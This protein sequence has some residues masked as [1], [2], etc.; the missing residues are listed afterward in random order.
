MEIDMQHISKAFGPNV[1]LK[2]VN[3]SVKGG[4]VH[5]LMG[6]NG[7]GKST[8]MNI[9][10]GLL[11]PNGG[12]IKVDGK[13]THFASALEAEQHGISFIHQEMNNFGEMPI[14]DNMFLNKEIKTRFGFIDNV[15]MK[16]IAQESLAKLDVKLDLNQPIGNL[17]VGQQQM[18]EIAKSLMTDAKIIIMDEP[19]AALTE[20]EIGKLFDVIKS[21]KAQGVGIIYISHRMEELF[22]ISDRV[23]VMRDGLTIN[24]YNTKETNVKQI[25]HDMVGRDMGDFYPDR[26]PKF[27]KVM[28]ETN[29]LTRE[30]V[31]KDISF[32]VRSGEI[33]AFSG[34]MGAGRTEVMR[35]I[36]G[37][38]KLDSGTITVNGKQVK[39]SNP[40]DAIKDN[41]GFLTEDRKSEGLILDDSIA[42]NI[43][44]PSIEGFVKHGMIDRKADR[45][46]V[47]L[48][49]KRLTVKA[50]SAEDEAGSLSG[51]NQQKVVLAKWV[52]SG[53]QVLILDEPTRGVDVGAKREI[54]DLMNELTDRGT[55]IIMVSSDLDEVLGFSDNIAVLYEGKLM[56]VVPTATATQESVMTLATGGEN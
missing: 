50:N 15:K 26:H 55:A 38:D 17:S 33:L 2:D 4:E 32:S 49:M 8:M 18:I 29:K 10:T 48:L 34:L 12:S 1:V 30:G 46:F 19:T 11:E 37:I 47:N 20:N 54:Y 28:L 9:L 35:A 5:A 52:G 14:L 6:E 22:E 39:I 42:D 25:V 56:G 24:T 27:G 36:F 41:I 45:D 44:L 16:A 3:F 31:F 51:G 40:S 43:D 21:L 13:E 23:T 7:A 53:S